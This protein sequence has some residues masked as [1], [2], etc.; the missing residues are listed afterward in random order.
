MSV[1]RDYPRTKADDLPQI[2]SSTSFVDLPVTSP[3]THQ[4]DGDNRSLI[5]AGL[6]VH[7]Y[8]DTREKQPIQSTV[9]LTLLDVYFERSTNP[10]VIYQSKLGVVLKNDTR[11]DIGVHVPSWIT[12]PGDVHVG[13]A[14][15]RCYQHRRGVLW[16]FGFAACSPTNFPTKEQRFTAAAGEC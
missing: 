10:T 5:V 8:F 4:F 12:E 9:G 7:S 3:P 11:Q 13:L 6:V 15:R 2:L 16:G 1:P 14:S